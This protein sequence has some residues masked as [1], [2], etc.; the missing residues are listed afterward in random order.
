MIMIIIINFVPIMLKLVTWILFLHYLNQNSEKLSE[1]ILWYFQIY[2][3]KK[4]TSTKKSCEIY[5]KSFWTV[6]YTHFFISY[7]LKE[8]PLTTPWKFSNLRFFWHFKG[9]INFQNGCSK[10]Q[11]FK[12]QKKKKQTLP[13]NKL[14]LK[15]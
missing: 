3:K 4:R 5:K 1:I 10:H 14:T 12:G 9:K 8:F 11:S 7:L 2:S 6:V 13:E 15:K